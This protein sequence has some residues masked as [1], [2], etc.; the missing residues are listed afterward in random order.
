VKL[1][2]F[3]RGKNKLYGKK[4]DLKGS[5]HA[6]V[7]F[8]ELPSRDSLRLQR[9]TTMGTVKEDCPA[10]WSQSGRPQD[11]QELDRE[12]P[13]SGE[14]CQYC[15]RDKEAFFHL[16]PLELNSCFL[17]AGVRTPFPLLGT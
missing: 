14:H 15:C 17:A 3:S 11:G 7:D 13:Y 9:L 16:I 5:V 12:W 8:C 4:V 6:A 2:C 10:W 1:R